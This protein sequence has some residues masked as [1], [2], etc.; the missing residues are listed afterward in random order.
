MSRIWLRKLPLGLRNPNRR[1]HPL[2]AVRHDRH[3]EVVCPVDLGGHVLRSVDTACDIGRL[4]V[5]V[6]EESL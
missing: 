2:G 4:S 6:R 1:R 3:L 5:R